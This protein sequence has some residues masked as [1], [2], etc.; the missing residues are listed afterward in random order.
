M[1][2]GQTGTDSAQREDPVTEGTG[3]AT[4]SE[5]H[6]KNEREVTNRKERKRKVNHGQYRKSVERQGYPTK[7]TRPE[8]EGAAHV[9]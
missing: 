7:S 8:K 6:P 2:R 9:N 1:Q 3:D 4:E 5:E